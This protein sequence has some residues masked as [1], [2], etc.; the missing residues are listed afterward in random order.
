MSQRKEKNLRRF[1]AI[2]LTSSILLSGIAYA[3]E[4]D[5]E[6]PLYL[7]GQ[8]ITVKESNEYNGLNE[9][10][11]GSSKYGAQNDSIGE[12]NITV[13]SGKV[14]AVTGGSAAENG[15]V[16]HVGTANITIK[17][18]DVGYIQGGGEAD[19]GNAQSTVDT[20]N[21]TV[22][23]GN[24]ASNPFSAP[25]DEGSSNGISGGGMAWAG[26]NENETVTS[27]VKTVNITITGGNIYKP[28]DP[29][30]NGS[31]IWGGGVAGYDGT[32]SNATASAHVDTVN[33]NI[34]G[35]T[36]YT[37]VYAGGVTY[38]LTGSGDGKITSTVDN[39][40]IN[41]SDGEIKGSV[42]AGGMN[43]ATVGNATIN[44]SGGKIGGNVSADQNVTGSST[45]NFTKGTHSSLDGAISG[46]DTITVKEGAKTTLTGTNVADGTAVIQANRMEI[47]K[48]STVTIAKT[49]TFNLGSTSSPIPAAFS[50]RSAQVTNGMLNLSGEL[51]IMM[52][53]DLT[54]ENTTLVSHDT[55]MVTV[56]AKKDGSTFSVSKLNMAA[57]SDFADSHVN[58]NI[59]LPIDE[60]KNLSA[61]ELND[62]IEKA[63]TSTV[64][65]G[66]DIGN[67][68]NAEYQYIK[69][70]TGKITDIK[71]NDTY[72]GF[73]TGI[74]QAN[75][76][77]A[78]HMIE[79]IHDRNASLRGGAKTDDFWVNIRGGS[80]DIDNRYGKA[81]VK[82]QYY[83]L[84]YDWDVSTD[85]NKAMIGVYFSK[86]YGDI[87][88]YNIKSDID[89]AYDFGIYGMKEFSN[90]NYIGLVGRYGQTENSARI[91]E[92]EVDWKDKGYA[93]SAEFGKRMEQKSGWMLEPYMQ[94][95]Y[96]HLSDAELNTGSTDA[97]LEGASLLD[98]RIGVRFIQQEKANPK[99]MVYGGLAYVK[100][101][102]GDFKMKSKG[103]LDMADIDNDAN[104]FEITVGINRQISQSSTLN[105]NAKKELGDYDGWSLQGMV[106][107]AF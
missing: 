19:Y 88:Q 86:I 34:S 21:I 60:I 32:A 50:L 91:D 101:L 46:F 105:L 92:R 45:L 65:S 13:E 61:E 7:E 15:A 82:N 102:S 64:A 27:T 81:E 100:G 76:Y 1:V 90:G 42:Y 24:I 8:T 26:D 5:E 94:L 36:I 6:H 69:D 48:D 62:I 52:G 30:A 72:L 56:G 68:A 74:R 25:G 93:L 106:N 63:L 66:L 87:T 89:N 104:A 78:Q 38:D 103:G 49:M 85:A 9:V 99:N 31:G 2:Y 96:N 40:T 41:I 35:G 39:A 51:K 73:Y 79:N 33:M 14:G 55:G 43:K 107:V 77:I 29:S 98:G 97:V 54:L 37:D 28:T 59:D 10:Y 83:Q 80:T 47:E 4:S 75:A 22:S 71:L 58:L 12:T 44:I 57:T 67:G 17:G 70:A 95:T 18:G 23:G 53:A 3:E 84:G 11:G 20:V 16:V